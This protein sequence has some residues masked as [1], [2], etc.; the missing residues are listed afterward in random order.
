MK[1]PE[2]HLPT[3]RNNG[4]EPKGENE[5][6]V[7]KEEIW[8]EVQELKKEIAKI[9]KQIDHSD[10]EEELQHQGG[11]VDK[12]GELD[13]RIQDLE[14][15][16]RN[17]SHYS[18][19]GVKRG[20][21]PQNLRE[22][23]A[24]KIY[25]LLRKEALRRGSRGRI[26]KRCSKLLDQVGLSGSFGSRDSKRMALYRGI[27]EAKE[28]TENDVLEGFLEHNLGDSRGKRKKVKLKLPNE[29]LPK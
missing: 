7:T 2:D 1:A 23:N 21:S 3:N 26:K 15:D 13:Q 16:P 27:K 11:I 12:I 4:D 19:R 28:Y 8:N 5:P 22:A 18:E 6:E 9:R 14:C 17:E 20:F 25:Q 24:L 10:N 29:V